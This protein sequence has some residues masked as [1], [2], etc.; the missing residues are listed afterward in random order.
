MRPLK[1]S[2]TAAW[3]VLQFGQF[4]GNWGLVRLGV[5]TLQRP[6]KLASGKLCYR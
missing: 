6:L 1:G 5:R 4:R 2:V 3:T